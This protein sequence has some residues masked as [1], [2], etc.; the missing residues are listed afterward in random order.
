MENEKKF[1]NGKGHKG[2]KIIHFKNAFHGRSGYSLSLTNTDPSKYLYFPLF[3]WPR[4]DLPVLKFP[5]D[6]EN[7]DYVIRKEQEIEEQLINLLSEDGDDIAA[8]ILEPIQGE[9][10]DNHIRP[11]FWLKLRNLANQYDVLLIADEVQSGIGLTGKMW[12]YEHFGEGS[13]ATPDIVCFGKKSQVCGIMCT[14]RI[15][16]INNN[17]FKVPSRINSTWG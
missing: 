6:E 15:D 8:I 3:D 13:T 1:K 5:L 14:S 16:E 2:H 11:E 12:A 9:G 4:F 17:V 7:I 10:G